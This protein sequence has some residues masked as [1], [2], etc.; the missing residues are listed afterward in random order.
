M[1]FLFTSLRNTT[2]LFSLEKKRPKLTLTQMIKDYA[3]CN[4]ISVNK[5]GCV[6]EQRE[7]I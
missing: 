1:N 4:G 5:T 2:Y 7:K 3:F 6:S